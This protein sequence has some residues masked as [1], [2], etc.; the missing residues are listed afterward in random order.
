MAKQAF[1]PVLVIDFDAE[2]IHQLFQGREDLYRFG[3]GD[4]AAL[5]IE[6]G[7]RPGR[8]VTGD[9]VFPIGFE[10]Q[11]VF[12]SIAEL[13]VCAK[14]VLDG[15][16]RDRLEM[17]ADLIGFPF[18]LRIVFPMQKLTGAALAEVGADGSDACRRIDDTLEDFL[19]VGIELDFF[20]RQNVIERNPF[21]PSFTVFIDLAADALFRD[22]HVI[23]KSS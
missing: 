10:G 9:G 13:A 11:D 19:G 21:D 6:Q 15:D 12:G 17:V 8:I 20:Q 3:M 14:A 22:S 5:D 23:P 7:M 1:F 4:V 16:F 2:R 18:E